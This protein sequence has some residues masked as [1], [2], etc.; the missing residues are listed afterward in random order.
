[1]NLASSSLK[2]CYFPISDVN[3]LFNQ[4]FSTARK[5][6]RHLL[7]DPLRDCQLNHRIVM[8]QTMLNTLIIYKYIAH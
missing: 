4:L 6:K 1:M 3:N 8:S 2:D 7:L 5:A